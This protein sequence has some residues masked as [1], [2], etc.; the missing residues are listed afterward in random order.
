MRLA[1]GRRAV[2]AAAPTL[3]QVIGNPDN[4][5]KRQNHPKKYYGGDH[6]RFLARN[7]IEPN[8]AIQSDPPKMATAMEKLAGARSWPKTSPAATRLAM[9]GTLSSNSLR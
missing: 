3:I 9:S 2:L 6:L 5:D 8:S 7:I 4:R 1:L